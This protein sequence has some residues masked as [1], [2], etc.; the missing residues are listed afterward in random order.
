MLYTDAIPLSIAE[1]GCLHGSGNGE[2]CLAAEKWTYHGTCTSPYRSHYSYIE[3]QRNE[4][5]SS[6]SRQ[7][8]NT[9]IN[10]STMTV[11]HISVSVRSRQQFVWNYGWQTE[12]TGLLAEEIVSAAVH[13]ALI[14]RHYTS[15]TAVL[16][17][18]RGLQNKITYIVTYTKSTT[19][20]RSKTIQ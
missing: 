11:T 16:R 2:N 18:S 5:S 9:Q 7:L 20:W 1:C 4:Y 3:R 6:N 8:R 17:W 13:Y 15:H 19:N 14:Y 10:T 12:R